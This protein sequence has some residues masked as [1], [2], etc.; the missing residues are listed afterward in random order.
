ME[1]F[2]PA[3]MD[4]RPPAS[5]INGSRRGGIFQLD[6]DRSAVLPCYAKQTFVLFTDGR[7]GED[8]GVRTVTSRQ[9]AALRLKPSRRKATRRPV[10]RMPMSGK[11]VRRDNRRQRLLDAAARQ[12]RERGF[13]GASMRAIAGAAGM[14]AGSAYYHFPSKEGIFLAVHKEGVRRITAAVEAAI[15]EVSGPWERLEAAA[16]SHLALLLDGGDYAQVVICD[17]PQEA[18]SAHSRLIA[19]RDAYEDIFRDLV[20]ALPLPAD[21]D[22]GLLRLMLLGALNWSPRWYRA[23]HSSPAEIARHFVAALRRPPELKW[24]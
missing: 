23:G 1:P 16:S 19:L 18:A 12:F 6:R 15:A 2:R 4:C 7:D 11:A 24:S 9:N 8:G 17:P 20:A 14:L 22:R 5:K 10:V 13:A 21:A 3:A